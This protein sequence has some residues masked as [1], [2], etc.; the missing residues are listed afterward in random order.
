M[1]PHMHPRSRMTASLF[2]TTLMV[3]FLVVAAPHL[4]PCPVDPRTL[5]DA[6]DPTRRRRRRRPAE[7]QDESDALGD[8]GRKTMEQRLNPKRE[9]PIPKPGGLVGQVLGMTTRGA[10]QGESAAKHVETLRR[11]TIANSPDMPSHP[12][13]KAQRMSYRIARGETGVLTFEPYKSEILPSWRFK[14]PAIAKKSSAAIYAKFLA[15]HDA[16]DFIGMD[17]ARKFLQMG[18]TR[19]KRYANHKG[20]RKYDKKTGEVLQ[21]HQDFEGRE[22]KLEA[23]LVFREV[24]DRARGHDGYQAMKERFVKEQKEWDRTRKME[25]KKE[26]EDEEDAGAETKPEEERRTRSK[27]ATKPE[28]ARNTRSKTEIKE[29]EG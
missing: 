27:T 2:T 15:Y 19:A 8:E 29:E 23:S 3:S 4:I 28:K 14:T 17:M 7:S 21:K 9:C 16:D 10:H 18:M 11:S 26:V 5:N 13:T 24:W 25:I 6:A 22:E 1:P 20:G 12:L